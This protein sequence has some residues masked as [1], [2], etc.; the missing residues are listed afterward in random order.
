MSM[1]EKVL[2]R[3]AAKADVPDLCRLAELL[4]LQHAA[5][6]PMRYRLPTSVIDAYAE[7]LN[8]QLDLKGTVVLVA[9]MSGALIGYA[10]ARVEPPCLLS[11]TGRVGWVHDLYVVAECRGHGI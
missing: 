5:Y 6:D 9:E 11:L 7:L 8:E 4:A 1:A 2:I 3:P 10:F